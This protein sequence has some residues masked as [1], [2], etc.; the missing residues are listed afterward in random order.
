MVRA[1]RQGARGTRKVSSA[2]RN[3]AP[4]PRGHNPRSSEARSLVQQRTSR[5]SSLRVLS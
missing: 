5:C 3:A 2:V 1:R 4:T